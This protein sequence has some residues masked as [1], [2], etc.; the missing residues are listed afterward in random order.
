MVDAGVFTLLMAVLGST[1]AIDILHKS[2]IR[3]KGPLHPD[4][5]DG[6]LGSSPSC[7]CMGGI[8]SLLMRVSAVT[9]V[10]TECF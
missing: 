7:W 5:W 4:D 6:F 1:D 8:R 3:Y 2:S 9:E 10:A